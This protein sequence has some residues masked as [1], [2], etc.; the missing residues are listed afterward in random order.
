[1]LMVAR[2]CVKS[3]CTGRI[4]RRVFQSSEEVCMKRGISLVNR[5]RATNMHLIVHNAIP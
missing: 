4:R 2:D 1:M 5:E 3:D